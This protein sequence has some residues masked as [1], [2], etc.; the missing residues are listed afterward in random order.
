MVKH[1]SVVQILVAVRRVVV[2]LENRVFPREL[3]LLV[4][5]FLE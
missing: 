4:W 2:D 3:N 5:W 1:S